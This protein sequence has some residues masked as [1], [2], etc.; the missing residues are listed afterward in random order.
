ME[1]GRD[2]NRSWKHR[3]RRFPCSLWRQDGPAS[4]WPPGL[5]E[6]TFLFIYL[7]AIKLGIFFFFL[8]QPQAFS[9][10]TSNLGLSQDFLFSRVPQNTLVVGPRRFSFPPSRRL[11]DCRPNPAS[12]LCLLI[13]FYWHTATPTHLLSPR[14]A[15]ALPWQCWGL[16]TE[17]AQLARPKNTHV[18]WLFT[19]YLLSPLSLGN[20]LS[21]ILAHTCSAHVRPW[22]SQSVDGGGLSFC[23]LVF[24]VSFW[25]WT[26]D[27]GKLD[28]IVCLFFF[29]RKLE[30]FCYK[31][32][33]CKILP[34]RG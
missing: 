33:L 29:F 9:E 13:K 25:F 1:T 7:L 34:Q 6:N 32:T 23:L 24:Q 10:V 27:P 4:V 22:G 20:G 21:L 8:W 26:R 2:G 11:A 14:A 3:G 30:N 16:V 18:L 31:R 5:W 12:H 17:A 15:F 28:L 19:E